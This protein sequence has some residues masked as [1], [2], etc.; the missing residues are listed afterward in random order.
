MALEWK[1]DGKYGYY[2]SSYG[3]Y[4]N[5]NEEMEIEIRIW[6]RDFIFGVELKDSAFTFAFSTSFIANLMV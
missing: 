5:G 4:G 6:D 2:D 1:N 3:I